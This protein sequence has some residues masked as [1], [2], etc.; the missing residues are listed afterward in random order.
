MSKY[1]NSPTAGYY[2]AFKQP[3]GYEISNQSNIRIGD[4]SN[5]KV[6]YPSGQGLTVFEMQELLQLIN[7]LDQN[8]Q[9]VL[10]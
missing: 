7:I 4:Y 10:G 6:F 5:E 8:Q 1:I 3:R 9:N 2:K